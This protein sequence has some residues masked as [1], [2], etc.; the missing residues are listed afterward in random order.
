M[1]NLTIGKK[2]SLGFSLLVLMM[3]L[4][5]G[6]SSWML[7]N[8]NNDYELDV[9]NEVAVEK[10]AIHIH[11]DMLELRSKI[12]NFRLSKDMR[13]IEL[14]KQELQL[15]KNS[16]DQMSK[17][18]T[19]SQSI[20]N[21]KIIDNSVDHWQTLILAEVALEQK[22]GL[23]EKDGLLGILRDHS[24]KV[25]D[26]LAETKNSSDMM[27]D[28]LEL[29]R[30]ERNFKE[31]E[32]PV[33]A[34]KYHERLAQ[35]E[36]KISTH[37]VLK[38]Q[39]TE[40]AT[41]KTAFNQFVTANEERNQFREQAFKVL[42]ETMKL[43]EETLK[44][45]EDSTRELV[46]VISD[47]AHRTMSMLLIGSVLSVFFGITLAVV[48]VR[49]VNGLLKKMVQDLSTSANNLAS[50]SEEIASSSQ[51]LSSGASQQAAS[52]EETSSSMEEISIQTKENVANAS[53]TTELMRQVVEMVKATADNSH[54][55]A[56][57]SASAKNAAENGVQSMGAIAG[58]MR[59]IREGSEKI[60]DIIEVINEI[61]HQTKM[62]ATNAAIEAARAG[63]QGKGFAVVA[64]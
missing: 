42:D 29:R 60:T 55:A 50:A 39:I 62:L 64:D 17:I 22:I 44:L 47:S 8:I 10:T 46:A 16:V 9:M 26:R 25:E 51:M 38:N 11:K 58:A 2:L 45:E 1:A 52:L 32:N 57:L 33:D 30:S 61:T 53:S 20:K 48:F 27:I 5:G 24:Q 15:L 31:R 40:L 63:D 43:V 19:I 21:L 13:I 18:S 35:L 37:P 36:Q 49:M 7:Y 3:L 56:E 4:L 23:T 34:Q 28:Y 59:E 41:L 54:S 14:F 6:V 12:F